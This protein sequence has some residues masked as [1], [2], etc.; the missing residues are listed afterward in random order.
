[1]RSRIQSPG[2][3]DF[4]AP[5]TRPAVVLLGVVLF[6]AF[7]LVVDAA[8]Q[9][10][11]WAVPTVSDLVA[12]SPASYTNAAP[13]S[14]WI[15]LAIV[16]TT[17]TSV[18]STS[19]K[20][21][22][23]NAAATGTT[24]SAAA[25]GP[26]A[27]PYGAGSGRWIQTAASSLATPDFRLM[28]IPT[29]YPDP[30]E[31]TT[32]PNNPTT[33]FQKYIDAASFAYS[34]TLG[35]V[36]LDFPAGHYTCD[37][38]I[39][40]G[41]VIYNSDYEWHCK[42]RNNPSGTLNRSVM[43]T[44]RVTGMTVDPVDGAFL[45]WVASPVDYSNP[46]N[47]YG[48]SDDVWIT[49]KGRFLFDQNGKDCSLPLCRLMEVRRWI[50]DKGCFEVYHNSQ[51]TNVNN[52]GIYLTGRDVTW[53]AP[54]VRG[55]Q[56]IYQDGIHICA[57]RNITV[58]GGYFESGD[59]AVAIE[60]EA[61]GG[62]TSAPD[63]A[64]ENIT[65]SGFTV[66]SNRARAI[67][68]NGGVNQINVPYVNGLRVR[69]ITITNFSGT[70]GEFRQGGLFVG[71]Y[72][73]PDGIW[74]YSISNAGSG[75]T[76]G[77]Y[78]LDV[79]G[80]G[81]GSG[82]KCHLKVSGGRIVR[83][84]IA[85]VAGT[86]M[87]GSGYKQNQ[88]VVLS[89]LGN[90]TGGA[91]AGRVFGVP[92]DL[93]QRVTLD[94][95]T[96]ATGGI[97]HDGTE[98]YV[99]HLRGASDVF[100]R[101]AIGITQ[102]ATNPVHRPFYILGCS[103]V[104]LTLA[105]SETQ[106]GGSINTKT[107]PNCV[108]DQ[109][110]FR[111]CSF[112]PMRTPGNGVIKINGSGARHVYVQNS[113]FTAIP[114]GT[115]AIYLPDF[116]SGSLDSTEYLEVSNS[117][118]VAESATPSNVHAVDFVPATGGSGGQVGFF[119]FVDNEILGATVVDSPSSVQI[120]CVAYEISGN[121]G[122]YV[123]TGTRFVNLPAGGRSIPVTVDTYT[124]LPD[125]TEASL[126]AMHVK[127]LGSPGFVY[128]LTT[129]S[130]GSFNI[131]TSA[132]PASDVQFEV[133]L[134]TSQK[135]VRALRE[136]W[137]F[138]RPDLLM[139]S[140]RGV[141]ETRL[142]I[143]PG[144]SSVVSSGSESSF[145]GEYSEDDE[146]AGSFLKVV[147]P[148]GCALEAQLPSTGVY[149]VLVRYETRA[150]GSGNSI[151]R[152]SYTTNG[153]VY[154]P[155]RTLNPEASSPTMV[156]LDFSGVAGVANNPLFGIR[157]DFD[158]STA[159]Q[160][161]DDL[162]MAGAPLPGYLAAACPRLSAFPVQQ[163]WEGAP[164]SMRL[165]GV[166]AVPDAHTFS[167]VS[168]PEGLSVEASGLV[169]WVP[170]LALAGSVQTVVV[171]VRDESSPML[172][173]LG[174]I[175]IKVNSNVPP[176]LAQPSDGIV[177]EYSPYTA[178]L[179][180]SDPD[181]LAA[182]LAYS[183]VG[184]PS[185]LVV[186]PLGS[187][188]WTPT[189]GQGPGAVLVTVR[190]TDGGSP[191]RSDEKSFTI[192]VKEVNQV[193]VVVRPADVTVDELSPLTLAVT[194]S[195]PDLPVQ[196]L[197][198]AL[199]GA[200]AGMVIDS[201]G[202]LTWTPTE[203][204]GP[205]VYTVGV[206]VS[207]DGVPPLSDVATFTVTVRESNSAPILTQIPDPV[208]REL[209]PMTLRIS[210]VDGDHPTQ[211]LTYSLVGGP[212]GLGVT[213]SGVLT[214]TPTEAQGPGSHS[215]TVSVTDGGSPPLTDLK[216]FTI[217]VEE[218]NT[219]PELAS[220]PDLTV[221]EGAAVSVPLVA[222]DADVP[223]QRLTYRIVQGPEGMTVDAAG[224]ILW[225]PTEGQGPG[226]YQ[227]TAQVSDEGSPGLSDSKSFLVTV[228]EVNSAPVFDIPSGLIADQ[229]RPFTFGLQATDSDLPAQRIFYV[230]M[231]GPPG[232][233]V[234]LSGL[235]TWTPIGTQPPGDYP[236]TVRVTDTGSPPA[237]ETQS[238]SIS[239][240]NPNHAPVMSQPSDTLVA[241]PADL[242][243]DLAAVDPDL[244]EQ[245]LTFSLVS[246]PT[247][248]SVSTEGSVRWTPESSQS[249]G[250]YPVEVRVMDDGDPALS[251]TKT[252]LV[253]VSGQ[254]VP[255]V[256]APVE[257][258]TAEEV[259]L[260]FRL[261]SPAGEDLGDDAAYTLT[262]GPPGLSVDS[263][264]LVRWT[265]SEEQGPGVYSLQVSVVDSESG[266]ALRTDVLTLTVSEVN[267]APVL[268][269]P[270]AIQLEEGQP[271]SLQLTA[272]DR[273]VPAQTLGYSLLDGPDGLVVRP[274]G[275]VEWTPAVSQGP[276]DYPVRVRVTDG[277]VPPRTTD[278][279]FTVSVR[280]VNHVPQWI[281]PVLEP[282]DSLSTLSFYLQAV[283][284]DIPGQ[285]LT[286]DLVNGP[287]G[288]TVSPDGLVSWFPGEAVAPG[289][290]P[291]TVVAVD[292]GVPPASAP[293]SFTVVVRDLNAAPMLTPPANRTIAEGAVL[294]FALAAT[295]PD[296]GQA[297]IFSLVSGP[298]GMTV[299][300]SGFVEWTPSEEEG[301]GVFDVVVQVSDDGVPSLS[302]LGRFTVT[303]LGVN[304]APELV[305]P[306]DM[307]IEELVP[308]S[309]Q[310]LAWDPNIPGQ[311]LT[312]DLVSGPPGLALTAAGDLTWTPTETQGPGTFSVTV[313][314]TDD[315]VPAYVDSH[316]FS[317]NVLEVN[318][319]PILA[320][321]ADGD[322]IR[323]G[324]L[325]RS[326]SATDADLPVQTLT[327]S[328]V[329]GPSGMTVSPAGA[330]SWTPSPSQSAGNY[331]ISVRVTDAGS[332]PLSDL[333]SFTVTLREVN[334][335]PVLQRPADRSGKELQKLSLSLLATDADTP[336]Q[337]LTYSLV[338]GPAGLTV[339]GS[340][341]VSWTPTE[342][343]GPG[344]FPVTVKVTDNGA[345]P[346]ADVRSFTLTVEEVDQPPVPITPSNKTVT[347][348]T[349]LSFNLTA[350]DADLPAQ[351]LTFALINGPT[352]MAV[353]P[354]GQV[355]WT[356]TEV[357]GPGMY[358]VSVTVSDGDTPTL[359]ASTTF[360]V[361]VLEA[362]TAPV[363]VRPAD[364]TVVELRPFMTPLVAT[365]SDLP[366]Q[367]LTYSLVS[368]PTGLTVTTSGAVNWTPTEEQGP[369]VYSV[370]VKVSDNAPVPLSATQT[371]TL[372]VVDV[373]SLPVLVD[374][375]DQTINELSTFSMT[376]SAV[377]SD[378]PPQ[379]LT[380]ALVS[381]PAGM[382]VTPAGALSWTP[383][384]AQGPGT[385]S[386]TV[387]V[388]DNPSPPLTES[389]SFNITVNEVNSAPVLAKPADRTLNESTSLSVTLSAT[390]ADVP[391]QT[392]TYGLAS[393][394]TGLTVGAAGAVSWT[395]SEAQG[396]GTYTVSVKV[397]DGGSPPMSTTNSFVVTV[398]EVNT[399]PVL[400][401]PA[402]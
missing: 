172:S 346:L 330:L 79:T 12:Q 57:G 242:N 293:Q 41:K 207:D 42:K 19:V 137:S 216:S 150:L 240:R 298:Q 241:L 264:G 123:T 390:D 141:A 276:G 262:E 94:N 400:V 360:V 158:T 279:E 180:S 363:L 174:S 76:D 173:T 315:G 280:D 146:A 270:E 90:G 21:W 185:G 71:S 196:G 190:V 77:Y 366:T 229:Y 269:T 307:A 106:R 288:L 46:D 98:P 252:F 152:I 292:D 369:G 294:G 281:A 188:S 75:Y 162:S 18:P 250:T 336:T 354:A 301:P 68:I 383:T 9:T 205:G 74:D 91:V 374:I 387:S 291:V 287:P 143:L 29:L 110:Y 169:S 382:S 317:I 55:G 233:D 232:L 168:G 35:R 223:A 95:F 373:N 278:S 61:A 24:N 358:T 375:P 378:N 134:D 140:Q 370:T 109:L 125:A 212:P 323:G 82:A 135:P 126:G 391:A 255:E 267:S 350:T 335:A 156:A 314:V 142:S 184:G 228:R 155:F 171:R 238:F 154:L 214:W 258:V 53:Y 117:R 115:S 186:S 119:R 361:T 108:V 66:K 340:G 384:E 167:L 194:A 5:S 367:L 392:L 398:N 84:V 226:M 153:F 282:L 215:V 311:Q 284:F 69:D 157:I 178:V 199:L 352:G 261:V 351:P 222:S 313:R 11:Y 164:F 237:S 266:D 275:L 32:N 14:P 333:A 379:V 235:L 44:E 357:Q 179:T 121:F 286:Y 193:P 147:N 16:T 348:L 99:L 243:L 136:Y 191:P 397:T 295:D 22:V 312:Y 43:R 105:M 204:Q 47:W 304:A 274:D 149:N 107:F 208:V 120:S 308:M 221:D 13:D 159:A 325:S 83:A 303:V 349:T 231:N 225:T 7:G 395:P 236:V 401:K 202:H 192:T 227:V 197:T 338:S 72:Q 166:A 365:D 380:Y 377:D 297:L 175:D 211:R 48:L 246:G 62:S 128:W 113:V 39:W 318:T 67:S 388:T 20:H 38:L 86:F 145:S 170:P 230:L 359:S 244:P 130:A 259:P 116:E 356:P 299:S 200:P 289:E 58:V 28:V 127:P 27:W 206:R 122:A 195:D 26:I 347:E 114:N 40:R 209:V 309:L 245:R 187:V 6:L 381:G 256:A 305:R 97:S 89:G 160:G 251:D 54:T 389:M 8:N 234:S 273:D 88:T 64:A 283:D 376:L 132:G 345:P 118:F 30:T 277:G 151:Q 161:L 272:S 176:T 268:P 139:E 254:E 326:L 56:Y 1:M 355:T 198:F 386:V 260:T 310:L 322:V 181:G 263:E 129:N 23:W 103:N 80:T 148:A 320:R 189:E 102:N 51:A 334:Q 396:P 183:L 328:L 65:L 112:G 316:T 371:F 59:D 33:H 306:D 344:V 321:P 253:A 224:M 247:G 92:N 368:G 31:T 96:L 248:L 100:I 163:A 353:S 399:A 85:K 343:Q 342:A 220:Q 210:A 337:T 331:L 329:T 332:A 111:G 138:N 81:G 290:Y 3:R 319:A 364:S 271:W 15:P 257:I 324:T 393:G 217:T 213:P 25:G 50:I 144:F 239:V 177:D 402:D 302:D 63:E 49:G 296:P 249:P 385:Y 362:N 265:P 131:Q 52:W 10:A 73:T 101:G 182:D 218:A 341:V 201:T 45:S 104:V 34:A 394:P 60:T 165:P 203:E 37:E 133:E 4:P 339:S 87:V 78:V 372:N 36:R 124:G 70:C 17:G 219:P 300:P 93:I 285:G 2:K 327:Y